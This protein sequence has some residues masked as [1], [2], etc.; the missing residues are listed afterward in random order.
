MHPAPWTSSVVLGD[1][2]TYGVTHASQQA[3]PGQQCWCPASLQLAGGEVVGRGRLA[4]GAR[5]GQG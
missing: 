4:E 5:V 3:K 2:Q 1:S